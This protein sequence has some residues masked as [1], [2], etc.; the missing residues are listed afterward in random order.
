MLLFYVCALIPVAIGAILWWRDKEIVWWEW[1][2]GSI[3]AFAVAGIMH[4]VAIIGMTA[5]EETW[6]GQIS[7]ISYFPEW[8]ERYE[9]THTSTTTD[10]KGH[11]HTRTWTTT[12]YDTHS[13]HWVAYR[14]FG[15]Y[16]DDVNIEHQTY[17][18]IAV[19]FGGTQH[20]D[21]EQSNDHFGGTCSS[22]D[23]SIYSVDNV[24]GYVSPVTTTRRFENKI[25][26]APT[27]F[28]FSKVPTNID[29]YP[30][31]DN[32]DWM[33]SD[34]LL[35]TASV[36]VDHYKWDCMNS[37]LGPRK[38]VNVIMVG[39]T[40]DKSMDYGHYQEAKWIGGKKNDLVITFGG[41]S[42]TK[43]ATWAYV[44]GWTESDLVKEDIQSMLL[45]HPIN[46]D[47]IPLISKEIIANYKIK[48]WHKFDYISIEP[49]TWSY[50]V[51]FIS[52]IVV[53]GGLYLFFQFNDQGKDTGY[54][55]SYYR[56]RRW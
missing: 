56:R 19:K 15:T 14:D 5:D 28:S 26:A 40:A 2:I 51:Y 1:L 41:G 32:P 30:W 47:L 20:K 25:K 53:Q 31:P 11:S 9:E 34:R 23:D 36:L 39:F 16:D 52:M 35:G 6:S 4:A 45:S 50:W 33:H 43:P 48:D 29:V 21:G 37:S 7:K 24:N 17:N 46:N 8:T 22:G 38:K 44:F 42:T 3:A 12:E 54:S 27:L 55:W 10:S 18:E 13:E 49:P